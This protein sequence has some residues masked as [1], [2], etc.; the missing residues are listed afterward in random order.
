MNTIINS[1]SEAEL[2]DV[3]GGFEGCPASNVP[4]GTYSVQCPIGTLWINCSGAPTNQNMH[5][6]YTVDGNPPVPK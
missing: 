4:T 1:L 3:V 6:D 2:D 5:V